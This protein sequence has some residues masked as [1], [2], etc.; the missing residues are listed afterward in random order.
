MRLV[1]FFWPVFAAATMEFV[2]IF[3]A[4]CN[5]CV[6]IFCAAH[7]LFLY[8]FACA[9]VKLVCVFVAFCWHTTLY[10]WRACRFIHRLVE[11][12]EK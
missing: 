11:V 4:A 2:V 9:N 8:I 12:L 7:A 6:F 3:D 10:F 5:N 1:K